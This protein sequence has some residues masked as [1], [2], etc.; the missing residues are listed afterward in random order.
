MPGKKVKEFLD[1]QKVRYLS[2]IHSPAYTALDIAALAHVSGKEMAK[3]VIVNLDGR[4]AMVILPATRKLNRDL[5]CKAAGAGRVELATEEEFKYR[6]P[7][8]EAGAM[9]PFG[10]LYGLPVYA[11]EKL[12]EDAE[13]VFNAGSHREL[14]RLA[15]RDFERL[16]KP[17]LIHV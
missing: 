1:A 6:F 3:T 15:Y 14:I 9:P 2:I 11:D 10:N 7:D 8:C 16:V 5:L 4:M 12:A 13:I 17:V